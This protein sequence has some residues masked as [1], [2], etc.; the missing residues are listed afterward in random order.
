MV[1]DVKAMRIRSVLTVKRIGQTMV[2]EVTVTLKAGF[3]DGLIVPF[4]KAVDGSV[5][6]YQFLKSGGQGNL[7]GLNPP[8]QG[9]GLIEYR[10][11]AVG[12]MPFVRAGHE[13]V[14]KH[15][16][17]GTLNV[18]KLLPVLLAGFVPCH[19]ITAMN[20]KSQGLCNL[21]VKDV[22]LC[23]EPVSHCQEEYYSSNE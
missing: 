23:F 9:I 5:V 11:K 14:A 12:E 18:V 10:G 6:G 13:T 19:I 7:E 22:R 16:L 17:Q 1:T 3:Y 2:K 15:A 21:I 8:S 20:R 4:Y